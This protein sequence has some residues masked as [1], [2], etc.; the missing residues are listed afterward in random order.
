MDKSYNL[1]DEQKQHIQQLD[2]YYKEASGIF[3]SSSN[4]ELYSRLLDL[5]E[6]IRKKAL[7]CSV[8]VGLSGLLL[9]TTGYNFLTR[10]SNSFVEGIIFFCLGAILFAGAYPLYNFLL[11]KNR[12]KYAPVVLTISEY[13][14]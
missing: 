3:S 10:L 7:H 6:G 5:D 12:K 2:F 11:R 8:L 1:T 4:K 14:I 13:L 9:L